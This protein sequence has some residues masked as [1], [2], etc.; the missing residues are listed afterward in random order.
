MRIENLDKLIE[1]LEEINEL[2]VKDEELNEL[3]AEQEVFNKSVTDS[4]A[5][6]RQV[7]VE[8]VGDKATKFIENEIETYKTMESLAKY[9]KTALNLT[10]SKL[11]AKYKVIYPE[12]FL[13]EVNRQLKNQNLEIMFKGLD[14]IVIKNTL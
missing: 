3:V 6:L 2:L 10:Q 1:N 7:F 13:E 12:C 5:E 11:T 14:G 9:K 8:D 4:I